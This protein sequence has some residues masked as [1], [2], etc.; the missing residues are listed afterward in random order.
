MRQLAKL[1]TGKVSAILVI[2]FG[3][4][5][6][7]ALFGLLPKSSGDSYPGT[8]LPSDAESAKVSALLT[9]FP[10]ADQ[11]AGIIVWSR[12]SDAAAKLSDADRAAIAATLPALAKLSTVPQA[13]HPVFSDDGSAAYVAVPVKSQDSTTGIHDQAAAMRSAAA[14][15]LP[16]GLDARLTGPL[17]FQDDTGNAFA[18]ADFRLLLVT[19]LVVA[20]LLLV[21]YRSPILWIVPLVVVGMADGLSRFVVTAVGQ[22]VGLSM[23]PSVLG[24]LSVLVFGAGTDYALLLIA[25][26]R[27]ELRLL[28]DRREAMRIAVSGAGPAILASGVTVTL[29]L[30]MLLFGRL[31]SERALGLACAIGIAIALCFALLLLPAALVVC[32]RGLFWPF[33][34]KAVHGEHVAR[35]GVWDRIGGLVAR[36][37]AIVAAAVVVVVGGLS[38]GVIGFGIG[39]TQTEELLGTP[40]SVTA[41]E[42]LQRSFS[43][44]LTTSTTVLA[45]DAVADRAL[46]LA[47]STTGVSKASA[48]AS[49]G[50]WTR[51]DVTL[52]GAPQGEANF[53]SVRELRASYASAGGELAKSLVG[54]TEATA[55]DQRDLAAADRQLVIPLILGVVFVV[56]L[57]LLRSIVAPLLLLATVVGTFFAALGAGRWVFGLLGFAAYDTSV[58][59]YS[60]LFLVALGIDYNIFLITRAKEERE[61]LG[62]RDGMLRA[63][64]TTGGVITSAGVLLAAVFVV[65]GV[66]PVVALAQIGVIVCIGVLLDT[67]AVRTL[68]VPA[69]VLLLGDRFWWPARVRA[70]KN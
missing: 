57:V 29:S 13:V 21:T 38:T 62:T 28:D 43:P 35:R 63:L 59:L 53:A 24:I 42:V 31:E 70:L 41:E 2:V 54:G 51:I 60:F 7:G 26:Y 18:G 46:S 40:S 66:L 47:E 56:L 15:G 1:E 34:P 23:D 58:V 11:S 37:T 30:G 44:G 6:V 33:V 17:G 10:G 16:S 49:A 45:K 52:G 64:A 22:A 36:R 50:G 3:F 19:A 12:G 67:L 69:L 14:T 20:A 5:I 61:R 68:L 8:G 55:L 65:L 9:K 32:G 4:L 25:R 27:E 39:L 48:G